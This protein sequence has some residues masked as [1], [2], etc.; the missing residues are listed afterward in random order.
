MSRGS[1]LGLGGKGIRVK[2]E[3]SG[4]ACTK[5]KTS[6]FLPRASVLS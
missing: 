6:L 4:F 2:T 5:V 1:S 3:I